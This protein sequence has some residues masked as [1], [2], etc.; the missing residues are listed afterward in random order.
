MSNKPISV[1][2]GEYSNTRQ[3]SIARTIYAEFIEEINNTINTE[4]WAIATFATYNAMR[5]AQAYLPG[6]FRSRGIRITTHTNKETN[7]LY[8]RIVQ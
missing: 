8:V 3:G 1:S 7:Q 4:G 5:H 6:Y 2:T